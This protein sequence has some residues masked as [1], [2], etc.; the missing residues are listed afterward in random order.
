MNDATNCR[1]LSSY[2][3][4]G[5]VNWIG[6]SNNLQLVQSV[7]CRQQSWICAIT[8]HLIIVMKL[9]NF[10]ALTL[11]VWIGHNLT[12]SHTMAACTYPTVAVDSTFP[13]S[14]FLLLLLLLIQMSRLCLWW[15]HHNHGGTLHKLRL[16][17]RVQVQFKPNK[18][19][20]IID[21]NQP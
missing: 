16:K 17:T 21:L 20:E 19:E 10:V 2:V 11:V 12:R 14:P 15:R 4:V 13:F 6:D 9:K 8:I 3:A 5:S 7:I 18:I 1:V